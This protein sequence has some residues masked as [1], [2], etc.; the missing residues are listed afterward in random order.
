MSAILPD[1]RGR[2]PYEARMPASCRRVATR[3]AIKPIPLM[4]V[5]GLTPFI[6]HVL[7]SGVPV[8]EIAMLTS[9]NLLSRLLDH[10]EGLIPAARAYELMED[11]A[12]ARDLE[13]LGL[14][15][16]ADT[17]I[18][19]LG[20]FG[21][22]IAAAPTLG[23]A[24]DVLV[25]LAPGFDTGSRWSIERQGR[26]V[27]LCHETTLAPGL[28]HPQA[29]QYWLG[30]ALRLLRAGGRGWGPDEIHLQTAEARGVRSHVLMAGARLAFSQ[31]AT[32]IGFPASLLSGAMPR[33]RTVTPIERF[34]LE[35]WQASA[36]AGDFAGSIEQVIAML[37]SPDYP[38]IDAV[39]RAVGT[40]V[41]TLQRR[42]AEIGS[43]Y[44]RVLAQARLG[45]AA[46][47][48]S[49]TNATIL[50]IALDLGYSDH[51][52]F[53]RAFRR[54]MGMPPRDFRKHRR[55]TGAPV[56]DR[57]MHDPTWPA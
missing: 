5:A 45:T 4:R 22:L 26:R 15:A 34:D 31:P 40:G 30:I 46:R 23:D 13:H 16:G 19:A 36:P 52:H 28:S 32:A 50:D 29:D 24:L 56:R 9:A 33:R 51:A 18:D 27:R 20:I 55:D 53:T 39:A 37:S 47:L 12:A 8:E 11:A 25:R 43:S 2:Y 17:A 49:N 38:R 6:G 57:L 42:L 1:S 7:R 54:W 41:R 10:R 21:R 35:R 3:F 44:E 14:L 48:L